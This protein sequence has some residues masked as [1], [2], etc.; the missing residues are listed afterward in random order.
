[1]RVVVTGA[2]GNVGTALLRALAR[3][4]RVESIVGIARRRPELRAPK[5]EWLPLDITRAELTGPF[6]GADAV[7][8]LAWLIQPGRD[9][10]L[11]R[12]VNVDGSERVF[13]AAAEAGVPA[14]IHASSV[15]TYAPASKE[16]RQ[17]ESW[18]TTGI[19]SS[20]YSHQK[21]E[22]ERALDALETGFPDLRVVRLRP[23]LVFQRNAATEIRRLFAGPFLPRSLVD[24]R[25]IPVVPDVPGLVLQAVHA[26]DLAD[27]Y[28]RTIVDPR[29]RGAYNIAAEPV[30]DPGELAR[31]LGARPVPFSAPLL[32]RLAAL[33]F[34]LRLWPTEPGWLDLALGV[35]VMDT[36]R[37][38][39][40]L[41]WSAEKSAGGALLELLEG[42]RD[43][44]G[45][46]TPPLDPATS[47][48]GRIH[49]FT[50]GVGARP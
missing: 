18:P 38:R 43:G 5:T 36:T 26:D 4:E 30:L 17:D 40:E 29:A 25:L 15:G 31:L 24:R 10:A 37:A 20:F 11:T 49:E 27:A 14:L 12:A 21:A 1:M 50:T 47:G 28:R 3:E 19:A 9:H 34:V 39:E 44:A 22:C 13:R 23:G 46:Q 33:A 45:D 2:S 35:P 16:R 7:V 8:H 48:R 42:I 6:A 32:R 41:G